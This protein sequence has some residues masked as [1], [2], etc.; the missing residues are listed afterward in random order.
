MG[1]LISA[2]ADPLTFDAKVAEDYDDSAIVTDFPLET[3]SSIT[4]HRQEKP[5]T[6]TIE[7]IISESPFEGQ[8][9]DLGEA[10]VGGRRG[11]AALQY[12]ERNRATLFTWVSTRFG[13]IPNLAVEQVKTS[14]PAQQATRF[15]LKLK[16]VAFAEAVI[17]E[18]P[19]EFV[20]KP[21]AEP[22]KQCSEQGSKDLTGAV[23]S[24]DG[25]L[26]SFLLNTDETSDG[27]LTRFVDAINSFGDN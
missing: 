26:G 10:N 6:L 18:I 24:R 20:P 3:G 23:N 4:D 22:L 19:A 27:A 15:S 21:P 5:R 12:F 9:Q 7:G 11:L 14:V 17:V 2:S 1:T 16:Q 8:A 13:A 25:E